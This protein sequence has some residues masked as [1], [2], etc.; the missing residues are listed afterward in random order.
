MGS[1]DDDDDDDDDDGLKPLYLWAREELGH[2]PNLERSLE[3]TYTALSSRGPRWSW[4][5]RE[6]SVGPSVRS[7]CS[8]VR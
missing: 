1:D 2:G 8:P 6:S 4:Q 3:H 7:Y 5:S